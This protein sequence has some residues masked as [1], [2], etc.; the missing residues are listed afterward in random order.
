[1]DESSRWRYEVYTQGV[2]HLRAIR[3]AVEANQ[4]AQGKQDRMN[5]ESRRSFDLGSSS[6]R[7]HIA[8]IGA[9]VAA[10]LSL[11]SA[12]G[13]TQ[14]IMRKSIGTAASFEMFE[15][16][17]TS[18]LGSTKA[19]R[20]EMAEL[21][22][23]A[24]ETPF[25]L[26]GVIEARKMMLA[27]SLEGPKVM[28]VAG[29]AAAAMNQ[30]IVDAI[31]AI[32]QARYGEMERLKMFGVSSAMIA[33][34]LGHEINRDTIEGQ[35]E[36]G[37]A[38]LAIFEQR[39]AGG[40]IRLSRTV[41]GLWSTLKDTVSQAWLAIGRQG[42]LDVVRTD[43]DR[44]IKF[45]EQS[46]QPGGPIEKFGKT[47]T[48]VFIE[49]DA[50]VWATAESIIDAFQS[51]EVREFFERIESLAKLLGISSVGGM[52]GGGILGG[53]LG[54]PGGII[55]GAQIGAV[56][57][58]AA[59]LGLRGVVDV[60]EETWQKHWN[61][62]KLFFSELS[63]ITVNQFMG[64]SPGAG[65]VGGVAAPETGGAGVP[66]GPALPSLA[67][68]REMHRRR[69]RGAV[70]AGPPEVVAQEPELTA[71]R[72]GWAFSVTPKVELVEIEQSAL[73]QLEIQQKIKAGW[74]ETTDAFTQMWA[75]AFGDLEGKWVRMGMVQ[76]SAMRA[77]V[78]V[79][80]AATKS[81]MVT[82]N[83]FFEGRL[84][85]ERF[86]ARVLEATA[87]EALASFLDTLKERIEKKAAEARVDA[88][89]AF[90]FGN[91]G[92]GAALLAASFGYSAL[93]G[94]A[95][96]GAAAIRSEAE[97][98]LRGLEKEEP[99]KPGTTGAG[100]LDT[101]GI[102]DRRGGSFGFQQGT[103]TA[104]PITFV[105]SYQHYGTAYF[106]SG[107][108]DAFVAELAPAINRAIEAGQIGSPGR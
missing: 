78:A 2:E 32:S 61:D 102:G 76:E 105:V 43:L 89:V 38:V 35:R 86:L 64:W 48:D 25:E 103:L 1:M 65:A 26:P 83:L 100:D 84:K 69:L 101:T 34:Q 94:I 6:L 54:G 40:M 73:K 70:A 62:V 93:A 63:K 39:Y 47:F 99:W 87:R 11:R 24:A 81:M 4:Q 107:S 45:I 27:M 41:G 44:L 96:G 98:R 33:K 104:A 22:R 88:A 28:R 59:A 21:V 15:T 46:S 55:P 92:R 106:G 30:T 23:F 108:P 68:R 97:E 75:L 51:G 85:Q 71:R 31:L 66:Y 60:S 3:Q 17:L 10:Y 82:S 72:P 42:I 9:T 13:L 29:D 49:I 77:V 56:A 12:I 58:P 8:A 80:Q 16:Q 74:W 90:A 7:T 53:V 95:G 14:T 20:A 5:Q 37:E 18:L 19:A 52:I 36:V 57:A 91:V 67:E 50:L 79:N